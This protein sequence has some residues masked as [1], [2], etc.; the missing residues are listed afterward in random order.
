M[1]AF[2]TTSDRSAISIW[3]Q[4]ARP[5][6]YPASI[7]PVLVATV[8]TFVNFSGNINWSLFPVILFGAVLFHTGTNLVSE[9]FDYIKGVDRPETFGSSRVLVDGLLKPKAAL[10]GGL[11]TF[12]VGFALGM[13]LVAQYGLPILYLGLAGL[14]GG[15]FYTGY[16]INYKYFALGDLGVFMLFGPLMMLGTFMGLTGEFNWEIMFISLPLGL[17]VAAILNANN[18]RDILH[19]SNVK[20]KTMATLLGIQGAKFEYYL[21]IAG[22]YSSVLIMI[23]LGML[24]PWTLLVFLSLKPAI[25]NIKFISKAKVNQ[26]ELIVMSD[27]RTAQH[28][29][30]FGILYAAGML[31]GNWI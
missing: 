27:V 3:F 26:P 24:S 20:V 25:D 15:I 7:I 12:A 23:A 28:Q 29:L 10:Y 19:D 22:A 2:S 9:Y 8:W 17:L 5:F 16:P 18:I 11:I 13:I 14:L 6:A 30:L 1:T 4:A 21:L 31:I